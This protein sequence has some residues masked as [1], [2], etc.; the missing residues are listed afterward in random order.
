MAE[1]YPLA[2]PEGWARTPATKRRRAPYRVGAHAAKENLLHELQLLG[3]YNVVISTNMPT[4]S[5]GMPYA[6][7]GNVE[8]PGVAVYWSTKAYKERCIACDKWLAVYDNVHAIGKAIGALR[9]LDRIGA[10]QVLERAF[11]AFGALPPSSSAPV[12]RPWWEVLEIPQAAIG[13]L[14]LAM[15]Q[16]RFRELTTKHHPDRGGSQA[17]MVELNKAFQQAQ[18]HYGSR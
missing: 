14:S 15:V 10:S 3:G 6:N 12:V 7:V 17:F 8:D 1:A 13:A 4:K 18:E 11:S 2:W 16:A 5:N 9:S